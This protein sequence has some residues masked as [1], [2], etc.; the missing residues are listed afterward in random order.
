MNQLITILGPTASGK[1]S[2]GIK[3]AREFNGEIVSA[4]SRQVYRSMDIGTGKDLNEFRIIPYHLIDIVSP[5]T[6]FNLAKYLKLAKRAI[7]DIQRRGKLPI[8]VG[9][10]GLYF[11]AVVDGYSLS[12][13]KPDK[14]LRAELEKKSVLELEQMLKKLDPG[15]QADEKNKRHLIRYIEVV[16]QTKQPLIQALTKRGGD[17]SCLV[18]GVTLPR[19]KLNEKIDGRLIR[20][21]E[22]EGLIEEVVRLRKSGVTWRRLLSFGLEYA[23]VSR[24]LRGEL[25]R[26]ELAEKLAVA[27]HQFAKRQITWLKRWERQGREIVWINT[28][29][30]AR[31]LVKEW[32]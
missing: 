23:F 20:R 14:K 1:S 30:Q 6:D 31:R 25:N 12:A 32:L 5:K 2:L 26:N 16:K 7:A 10:T 13:V 8:L 11:Q 18:L 9:G 21:L 15:F 4:D 19:H 24:Y 28:Y 29:D 22:R 17:Y 3:L 27:I